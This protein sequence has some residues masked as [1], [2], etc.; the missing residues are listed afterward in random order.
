MVHDP[1]IQVYITSKYLYINYQG[2]SILL[3]NLCTD[4]IINILR[5]WYIFFLECTCVFLY[6]Y[7]VYLWVFSCF[8]P[9]MGV[10]FDITM[11]LYRDLSCTWA[12]ENIKITS[13]WGVS[14]F[15]FFYY[16]ILFKVN[17]SVSVALNWVFF[18]CA[19]NYCPVFTLH[20]I[21]ASFLIKEDIV[22]VPMGVCP[23]YSLV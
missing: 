19:N 1:N 13:M 2:Y 17:F 9:L 8:V 14:H 11:F 18:L 22:Y 12:R 21:V 5:D 16:V 6:Y 23:L 3:M 20:S 10:M 7:N 15:S 4:P